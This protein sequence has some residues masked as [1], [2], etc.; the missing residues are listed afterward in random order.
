MQN[1]KSP[2]RPLRHCWQLW[3]IPKG[4]AWVRSP[5]TLFLLYVLILLCT[6]TYYLATWPIVAGDTDLWY[7]LNSGRYILEH[8]SLP[9]NSFFSF[10]SPPRAWIDYFWLF[11]VLVYG[12]YSISDYYG[13]IFFRTFLYGLTLVLILRL[14][15][16]HPYAKTSILPIV[17]ITLYIMLLTPRYQL[18]RPY[19]FTY[20]FIITF[21]SILEFDHKQIKYL[22]ILAILWMNLH[23]IVYPL[24]LFII[25]S[26][27]IDDLVGHLKDKI[28]LQR[29][30]FS[31]IIPMVLSMYAIFLTP[32]GLSLIGLPFI[33]TAYASQYIDRKSTRLNSSHSRASRM[34]SSA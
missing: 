33:P 21:F 34:P 8:K 26:Y 11:Q 7:H 28:P 12:L 22:P 15:L 18:I 20:L 13:L 3:V 6:T 1:P 29:K 4:S 16:K 30:T 17:L 5:H 9:H 27:L 23:G 2:L 14:L 25:F 10:I 31:Y 24:M 32:H 19:I